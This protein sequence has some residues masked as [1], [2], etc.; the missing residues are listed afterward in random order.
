MASLICT[1]SQTRRAH[2]IASY[3]IAIHRIDAYQTPPLA[4]PP[5]FIAICCVGI[6]HLC[7]SLRGVT[8]GSEVDGRA[9]P[10]QCDKS[11]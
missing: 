3:R 9:G 11:L 2:R 7:L 10:E 5:E 1:A 8:V 4:V 6:T